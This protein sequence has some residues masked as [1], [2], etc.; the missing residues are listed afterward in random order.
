MEEQEETFGAHPET[1]TPGRGHEKAPD[2]QLQDSII[3]AILKKKPT[4]AKTGA[5]NLPLS[6]YCGFVLFFSGCGK[7]K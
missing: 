4:I 2:L 5:K 1:L 3:V 6:I 7:V